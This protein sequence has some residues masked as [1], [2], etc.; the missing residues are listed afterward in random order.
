MPYQPL[1][2]AL[3]ERLERE[4]APDD[5][6]AD[7][8]LAELSQLLPELRD[9]YPDLPPPTTGDPNFAR[10]R[11]F[12]A[13]AQ[14]GQALAGRKPVVIF[15]DDL[16]WADAATLD[17]LPYLCRRWAEGQTRLL[18]L[19]TLRREALVT[20][21]NLREWLAQ[22]EREVSLTRLQLRPLTAEATQQLVETCRGARERPLQEAALRSRG[23]KNISP[24]HPCSPAPLLNSP[25]GSLA[26]TAGQPF[27]MAETIKMLVEQDILH[28]TYQP[29][30]QWAVDFESAIQQIT[31]QQQLPMPPNVREVI[32]TRLGRLSETA[33]ALLVAGAVLGRACS[34]ERLCQVSGVEELEGLAASG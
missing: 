32:L 1:V 30:G 15:I 12:E 5:L 16:Q 18:L 23:E 33:G 34:F 3:R 13:V 11:L 4:N 28:S 22:L 25:S 29:D 31:S 6:L 14:L 20:T 9:R 21:P 8:W 10:S 24:L 2:D 26:E 27:F 19:L 17:I 7:V